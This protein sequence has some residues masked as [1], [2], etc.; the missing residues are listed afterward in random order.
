M[1]SFN[2]LSDPKYATTSLV[3][4]IKPIVVG[5]AV[6]TP[7]APLMYAVVPSNVK[8]TSPFIVPAVPVA[9]NT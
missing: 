4:L 9:V 7:S 1:F 2:L 8:F 3:A 5:V 6:P